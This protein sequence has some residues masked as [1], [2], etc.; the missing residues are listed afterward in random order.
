MI[1]CFRSINTFLF[2]AKFIN[3]FLFGAKLS[4]FV[5]NILFC[6]KDGLAGAELASRLACCDANKRTEM[7]K[8][9]S[10]CIC[11]KENGKHIFRCGSISSTFPCESVG[12]SVTLSDAHSIGTVSGP[13]LYFKTIGCYMFSERFPPH[14]KRPTYLLPTYLST[15][16]PSVR[17]LVY[18]WQVTSES[19]L[20]T[21]P[22]KERA[23]PERRE[24]LKEKLG[25]FHT[26]ASSW[27]FSFC[28][29]HTSLFSGFCSP[30]LSLP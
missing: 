11:C 4:N 15:N 13:S 3:I 20:L 10:P 23:R 9:R 6:W 28:K 25:C 17:E 30:T 8:N 1:F 2:G 26:S 22:R 24:C 18:H 7:P 12:R 21:Q 29:T 16:L 14:Q 5:G 19:S 27:F